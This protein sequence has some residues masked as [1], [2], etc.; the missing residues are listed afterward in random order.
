MPAFQLP[1]SGIKSSASILRGSS[2][3]HFRRTKAEGIAGG[4]VLPLPSV[5][6]N[7]PFRWNSLPLSRSVIRR[8]QKRAHVDGWLDV[9]ISAINSLGG[10]HSSKSKVLPAKL[11]N[12]SLHVQALRG[13]YMRMGAPP[14]AWCAQGAFCELQG[15][16]S[17][18]ASSASSHAIYRE[19][20]V[21]LPDVG[22]VGASLGALLNDQDRLLLD[23][24]DGL[25]RDPV[26]LQAELDKLSFDRPYVDPVLRQS[27]NKYRK[28]VRELKQKGVVKY[29]IDH[30]SDVGVFFVK[31]KDGSLRLIFDTRVA[32]CYFKSPHKTDLMGPAGLA[33]VMC[34]EEG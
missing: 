27:S 11:G 3:H 2:G 6:I 16:C 30:T 26:S 34:D 21:A 19:G 8:L 29:G 28:F 31:K 17:S 25:Q 1:R 20:H 12:H 4:E 10:F 13:N 32:N 24:F 14:D 5:D 9:G 18:Y 33:D 22:F 7:H 15:S 23:S